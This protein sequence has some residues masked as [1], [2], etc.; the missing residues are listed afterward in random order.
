[1]PL[2]RASRVRR[3]RVEITMLAMG[4]VVELTLQ[5]LLLLLGAA[6]GARVNQHYAER[7]S[8]ELTNDAA[9]IRRHVSELARLMHEAG[10]IEAVF[11]EDDNLVRIVKLHGKVSARAHARG[12]LTVDREEANDPNEQPPNPPGSR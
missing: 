10:L 1:M 2:L 4:T 5:L 12:E 11:D 9:R 6:I 8:E 7:S 3:V